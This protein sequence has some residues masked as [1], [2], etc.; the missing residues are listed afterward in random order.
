MHFYVQKN[1]FLKAKCSIKPSQIV[2]HENV[3]TINMK[4]LKTYCFSC[5]ETEEK[6]IFFFF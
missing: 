2:A 1:Q 4:I 3:N 5:P 6:L